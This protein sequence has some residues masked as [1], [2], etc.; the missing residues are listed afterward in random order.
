MRSTFC[1]VL[2]LGLSLGIGFS[3]EHAQANEHGSGIFR[4]GNLKGYCKNPAPRQTIV[5]VDQASVTP[6][7]K[8]WAEQIVNKV[9]LIPHERLTL[10]RLNARN[11]TVEQLFSA[12]YPQLT[13]QETSVLKKKEG[14]IEALLGSALDDVK[15]DRQLFQKG[16]N[17]ALSQIIIASTEKQYQKNNDGKMAKKSIAEALFYD[18]KRFD[19]ANGIPRIII[20]SDMLQNSGDIHPANAAMSRVDIRKKA[21]DFRTGFNLAEIH[22][23]GIGGT[24][25]NGNPNQKLF[26]E[27]WQNYFLFSGA[28]LEQYSNNLTI[29]DQQVSLVDRWR[30]A[31]V[32]DKLQ[33]EVNARFMSDERGKLFNSWLDIPQLGAIPVKGKRK[34]NADFTQCV[35]DAE[36]RIDVEN[37]DRPKREG[38]NKLKPTY[39]FR[40]KDKLFLESS[41]EKEIKGTV[42]PFDGAC[43]STE[44]QPLSGVKLGKKPRKKSIKKG[45]KNKKSAKEKSTCRAAIY[46]VGLVLDDR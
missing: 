38:K 36:L 7:D 20:Y 3:A 40:A 23:F 34:C 19:L 33:V 21:R 18:E 32:I 13:A 37:L 14:V 31:I 44:P 16:M 42:K 5:Y 22:V 2:F 46:E 30:G 11:G 6:G 39:F 41:S 17:L 15:K 28:Y 1:T 43:L 25:G 12:C 35:V 26:A 10:L 4:Q 27:F 8:K 29:P 45:G 9:K 24:G